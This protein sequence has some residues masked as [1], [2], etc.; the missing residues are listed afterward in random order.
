MFKRHSAFHWTAWALIGLNA[1][2]RMSATILANPLAFLN[3]GAPMMQWRSA[4]APVDLTVLSAI[5]PIFYPLWLSGVAR[6]TGGFPPAMAIYAGLLSI[7]TPWVW[8]RFLREALDSKNVALAGWCLLAWLPSWIGIFSYIIP[9]TLLLLLVGMSL[10]MTFRCRRKQTFESFLWATLF[11][12]G[13][14]LTKM[15]VAPVAVI[16][17]G[18]LILRPTPHWKRGCLAAGLLLLASIPLGYRAYQKLGVWA[19]FGYPMH[20]RIYMVSG[21]ETLKIEFPRPNTPSLEYYL[22]TS[23]SAQVEPFTPLNHWRSSRHGICTIVIQLENGARD[24]QTAYQANKGSWKHR[25]RMQFE[26][27]LFVLWGPSW[28]DWDVHRFWDRLSYR[29]RWM[30]APLL[31]GV[32]VWDLLRLRSQR[33][34]AMVPL[35]TLVAWLMLLLQPVAPA[36]GRYRKP[37]EGLLIA[38]VL[39]L[40]EKR[41]RPI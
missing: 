32:V 17:L 24:W 7:L 34:I 29:F 33:K 28:P 18:W 16:S 10:W 41:N 9:E 14:V 38:N 13:S 31:L 27:V 8:Y 21:A 4:T 30:W 37:F 23:V 12:L 1:L 15:T 5:D 3:A 11:W 26:N 19:P 2:V 6:I 20:N 22:F 39:W 35:I 36:E 25:L 40:W